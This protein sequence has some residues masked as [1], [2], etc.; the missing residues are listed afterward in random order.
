MKKSIILMIFI[1]NIISQNI[2]ASSA[3]QNTLS[4]IKIKQQ[5]TTLSN[6]LESKIKALEKNETKKTETLD[7]L[8]KQQKELFKK[9]E[10]PNDKQS[11]IYL[12]NNLA[13]PSEYIKNGTPLPIQ[14]TTTP[15]SISGKILLILSNLT[16]PTA[17]LCATTI[18][19]TC[20]I[21]GWVTSGEIS[22]I[23][24][25]LISIGN[26]Q[27]AAMLLYNISYFIPGISYLFKTFGV[28]I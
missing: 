15:N 5:I 28:M 25:K 10:N 26:R 24:D 14:N 18:I 9:I 13:N 2:L 6:K 20:V 3:D 8:S 21:N 12:V 17:L 23:L 27:I 22:I 11:I 16:T 7:E 19:I 4:A 1:A